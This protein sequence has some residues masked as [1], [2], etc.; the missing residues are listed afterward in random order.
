M[1]YKSLNDIFIILS[2]KEPSS[3]SYE[4][5]SYENEKIKMNSFYATCKQTIIKNFI[6]TEFLCFI[7]DLSDEFEPD[8]RHFINLIKLKNKYRHLFKEDLILDNQKYILIDIINQSKIDHYTAWIIKNINPSNNLEFG[9]NYFYYDFV[10][11]NKIKE[12]I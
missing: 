8:N 12:I 5:C 11:N 9:K 6:L 7:F 3:S 4:T 1:I 2:L 10:D